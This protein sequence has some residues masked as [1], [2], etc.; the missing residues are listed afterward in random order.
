MRPCISRSDADGCVILGVT[1]GVLSRGGVI[2]CSAWGSY[3]IWYVTSMSAAGQAA[4]NAA[5]LMLP[6]ALALILCY[7]VIFML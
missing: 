3:V 5:G 1:W 6:P 4:Q 2:P 7:N